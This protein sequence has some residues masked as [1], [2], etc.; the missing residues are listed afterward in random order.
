[1]RITNDNN[2]TNHNTAERENHRTSTKVQATNINKEITDGVGMEGGAVGGW[3]E[4]WGGKQP[5]RRPA[6]Q[7]ARAWL[8]FAAVAKQFTQSANN[9]AES[10]G[11]K[12]S[13]HIIDHSHQINQRR[14]GK[15]YQPIGRCQLR[16]HGASESVQ[17]V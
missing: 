12:P 4:G 3:G 15:G 10:T 14:R 13:T 16:A 6:S 2:Y 11:T 17:H 1:M 7:P 8:P 5:A 9:H